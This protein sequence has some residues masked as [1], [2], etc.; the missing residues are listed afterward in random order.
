[1]KAYSLPAHRRT[2]NPETELDPVSLLRYHSEAA[3]MKNRI[4]LRQHMFSFLLEGEKTVHYAGTRVSI[5]PD[6]FLLLSA[7]NCLMSEKTASPAGSYRSMLLLF[8]ASVLTDF[9]SRHSEVPRT[10]SDQTEQEPFLVFE[11]DAFLHHFLESL[12]QMLTAGK[13]VSA[14]MRLVKLEE[15]LL[16]LGEHHPGALQKLRRV[17]G[18]GD[19]EMLIRQAV[20]AH[21]DHPVSVGELAFLC[22]TSLSTFKRR[23]AKLYGTSPNQWLLAKRMQKAARL[24]SQADCKASE[25]Y[26]QVGYENLSSFIQSFKQA[27]GLTPKQYQLA[28]RTRG[29]GR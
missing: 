1:M 19:Q 10:Q 23:F 25:I 14:R 15:L 12:H 6:Q 27:H 9:F 28:S 18:E 7:G 17:S 16:H 24:L 8:D 21:I 4:T 11:K 13:P 5:R 20:T 26:D 3:S 29:D 2:S 22:H